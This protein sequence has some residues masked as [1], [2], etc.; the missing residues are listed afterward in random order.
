MI[1]ATFSKNDLDPTYPKKRTVIM[2]HVINFQKK[3][4]RD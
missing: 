1:S 2:V 4:D 3:E